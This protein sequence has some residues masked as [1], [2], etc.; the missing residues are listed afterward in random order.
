MT[1]PA[2]VL[3]WSCSTRR[4]ATAGCGRRTAWPGF[5]VGPERRAF[6]EREDEFLA[7]GDLDGATALNVDFWVGPEASPETRS[8]V[9]TMQRHNFEVQPEDATEIDHPYE[10]SAITAPALLISGAHDVP[11]FTAI[12]THLA[13]LLPRAE[14]RHLDWAG[15]LPSL[16]RPG[17]LNPI[18]LDFLARTRA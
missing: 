18:L 3:R 15:H 17:L 12:A 10:P 9:G 6:G 16:E 4:C 11:E 7:A 13:G 2:T 8:L 14:H 1:W 5:P